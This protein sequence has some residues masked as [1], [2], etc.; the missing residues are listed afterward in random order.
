MQALALEQLHRDVER[1][2]GGLVEVVGGDRVRVAQVAQHHALA[3]EPRDEVLVLGHLRVQELER[4]LAAGREL[5]AAVDGAEPALADLRLDLEAVVEHLVDV[6]L[7]A[8]LGALA[9]FGRGAAAAA[10]RSGAPSAGVRSALRAADVAD[11]R[12]PAAECRGACSR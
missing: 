12:L 9:S 3:A 1:A 11:R 7:V 4:D 2:V 10:R 5:H 8:D 6:D